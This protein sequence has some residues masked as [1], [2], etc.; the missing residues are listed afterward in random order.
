MCLGCPGEGVRKSGPA[1]AAGRS[2]RHCAKHHRA[3]RSRTNKATQGSEVSRRRSR[4]S[5][6]RPA[7]YFEGS[8]AASTALL[9]ALNFEDTVKSFGG[10]FLDERQVFNAEARRVLQVS[11]IL[12]LV[13]AMQRDRVVGFG[14]A[15]PAVISASIAL[16][17][18][19]TLAIESHRGLAKCLLVATEPS[20]P[21]V[22]L[23]HNPAPDEPLH[24]FS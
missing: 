23:R 11:R 21:A 24:G 5:S 12:V 7:G 1:K 18:I 9:L 16:C 4:A 15:L 22:L 10:D 6:A 2:W 17:L 19:C 8:L 14:A 13:G 3:L 20:A